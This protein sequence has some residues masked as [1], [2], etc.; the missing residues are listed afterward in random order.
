M[1]G[2]LVLGG[3]LTFHADCAL[4]R[5]FTVVL[6]MSKGLA[7]EAS[8]VAAVGSPFLPSVFSLE[9]GDRL[10]S[11]VYHVSREGDVDGPTSNLV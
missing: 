9:Q 2:T 10:G 4:Q 1:C 8:G 7:T 6:V 3:D 11:N 5:C